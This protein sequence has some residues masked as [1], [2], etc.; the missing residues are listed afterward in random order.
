MKMSVLSQINRVGKPHTCIYLYVQWN[1]RI[2]DTLGTCPFRIVYSTQNCHMIIDDGMG[3]I[4][5]RRA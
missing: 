4:L 2:L 5:Q 3:S 1:L